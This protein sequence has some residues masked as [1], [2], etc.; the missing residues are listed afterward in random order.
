MRISD[1]ISDVCSSDLRSAFS[2]CL[3]A[4][5]RDDSPAIQCLPTLLIRRV[6]RLAGSR[7]RMRSVGLL[8]PIHFRPCPVTQLGSTSCRERV[9]KYVSITVVAVPFKKHTQ[10]NTNIHPSKHNTK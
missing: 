7:T 4:Y 6:G 9:C 10:D 5:S 3:R 2:R 1:W 8:L